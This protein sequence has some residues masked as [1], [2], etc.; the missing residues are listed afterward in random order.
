MLKTQNKAEAH[1]VTLDQLSMGGENTLSSFR[2]LTEAR[3][4]ACMCET[5]KTVFFFF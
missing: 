3:Q 1:Q 5:V 4:A 2:V